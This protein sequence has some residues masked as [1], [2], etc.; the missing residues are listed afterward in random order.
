M[1][2]SCTTWILPQHMHMYSIL[3]D[4]IQHVMLFSHCLAAYGFTLECMQWLMLLVTLQWLRAS[5]CNKMTLH[6]GLMDW[7]QTWAPDLANP[8]GWP[9]SMHVTVMPQ[10]AVGDSPSH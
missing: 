3:V 4:Y 10:P 5:A 2:L 7:K 1:L 9:E 6:G 8:D